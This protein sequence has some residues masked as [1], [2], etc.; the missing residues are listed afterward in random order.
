MEDLTHKFL[1]LGSQGG[2]QPSAA[3]SSQA[4]EVGWPSQAGAGHEFSE[5]GSPEGLFYG[6]QGGTLLPSDLAAAP[7]RKGPA[8]WL[9]G[10]GTGRESVFPPSPAASHSRLARPRTP[11][12]AGPGPGAG[13]RPS[14]RPSVEGGSGKHN[15]PR[16]PLFDGDFNGLGTDITSTRS[17]LYN[18]A[19]PREGEKLFPRNQEA[20]VAHTNLQTCSQLPDGDEA[21]VAFGNSKDREEMFWT[22]QS[23]HN[24]PNGSSKVLYETTDINNTGAVGF[25]LTSSLR[26]DQDVLRSGSQNLRTQVLPTPVEPTAPTQVSALPKVPL[27]IPSP[28]S[29]AAACEARGLN[30]TQMPLSSA[31]ELARRTPGCA[32]SKSVKDKRAPCLVSA[33]ERLWLVVALWMGSSG[34]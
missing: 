6:S 18:A 21:G 4:A 19:G 16:V 9:N 12:A 10:Q 22:G 8:A 2:P 23:V 20:T 24:A 3:S 33:G 28:S 13:A 17:S 11:E 5:E 34:C 27:S 25:G 1:C 31:N 32:L 7:R 29:G 26:G 30:S 15:A 14:G